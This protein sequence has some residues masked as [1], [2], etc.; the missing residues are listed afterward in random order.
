MQSY[1]DVHH[2][3]TIRI[4]RV[5]ICNEQ[6]GQMEERMNFLGAAFFLVF[7]IMNDIVIFGEE[8]ISLPILLVKFFSNFT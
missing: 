8:E 4:P 2:H 3:I 1:P 6:C 5:Y 7:S